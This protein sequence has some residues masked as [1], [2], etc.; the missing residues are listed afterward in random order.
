MI[1]A[2]RSVA[3]GIW[4]RWVQ[5]PKP[6][7]GSRNYWTD[8][9]AA[10]GNSGDGSYNQLAEFKAET[11]NHFVQ[12]RTIQSVI[13]FG[14]GDGNQLALARYPTYLGFDVS[15]TAVSLCRDAFGGDP[16]K[17]FELLDDYRGESAELALSL[18][19]VYHLVEDDVYEEYMG[20]LFDSAQRY[21]IIYSSDIDENPASQSPHVRHRK[22]TQWVEEQ[23]PAWRLLV[24]IPN[25]YPLDPATGRG[26]FADFSIYERT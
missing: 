12:S 20:R 26:S 13:E 25:R 14:C 6:F 19:V 5:P 18:D 17:R 1:K 16:T 22:F 23:R 2:I 15:A 3:R 11:L 8:R 24:R 7:P 9:Y 4:R 10:G 21:V